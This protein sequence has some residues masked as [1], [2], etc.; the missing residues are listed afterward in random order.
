MGQA[1]KYR[2]WLGT[3]TKIQVLAWDRHKNVLVDGTP[4]F[5]NNTAK[6]DIK[7]QQQQNTSTRF[8]SK[9]DTLPR[10]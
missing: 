10:K 7:T 1:Q 3:G 9:D 6:R 5:D 8:H 2:Y 4:P